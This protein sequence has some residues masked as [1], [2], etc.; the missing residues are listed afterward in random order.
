MSQQFDCPFVRRWDADVHVPQPFHLTV[1]PVSWHTRARVR[2]VG[3]ALERRRPE[4]G[5][6]ARC[7]P[8][9]SREPPHSHL[10]SVIKSNRSLSSTN[11][12]NNSGFTRNSAAVGAPCN[13]WLAHGPECD[14]LMGLVVSRRLGK[15]NRLPKVVFGTG[16]RIVLPAETPLARLH[17]QRRSRSDTSPATSPN[18]DER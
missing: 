8:R 4:R 12:R 11:V 13:T 18:K 16:R 15:H 9:K 10:A 3:T 7:W 6:T 5:H 2:S 17:G 1:A 14:R